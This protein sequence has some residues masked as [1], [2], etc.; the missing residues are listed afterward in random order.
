MVEGFDGCYLELPHIIHVASST[1]LL[2]PDQQLLPL[3]D[4][5][6]GITKRKRGRPSNVFSAP[7]EPRENRVS[8]RKRVVSPNLAAAEVP[9]LED[10]GDLPGDSFS[11]KRKR[12]RP[13]NASIAAQTRNEAEE[14]M[15]SRATWTER[16]NYGEKR[17]YTSASQE[18]EHEAR[19]SREKR[20]IDYA[21]KPKHTSGN[22]QQDIGEEPDAGA[23]QKKKN[24]VDK[25]RPAPVEEEVPPTSSHGLEDGPRSSREK[26]RVDYAE[27]R[28]YSSGNQENRAEEPDAGGPVQRKNRA[29]KVRSAPVEQE[30]QPTVSHAAVKKSRAGRPSKTSQAEP[31]E[32]E[33][34]QPEPRSKR[35][36]R[37][38]T[39]RLQESA[40]SREEPLLPSKKRG[41][42]SL[43]EAQIATSPL[44]TQV[45]KRGR[46]SNTNADEEEQEQEQEQPERDL[47]KRR[48]GRPSNADISAKQIKDAAG[49]GAS[50]SKKVR[51]REEDGAVAEAAPKRK[52]QRRSSPESDVDEIQQDTEIAHQRLV[53]RVHQINRDVMDTK[54]NLLPQG[55]ITQVSTLLNEAQRPVLHRL[56]PEQTRNSAHSAI[57]TIIK[58]VER[59]LRALPFPPSNRVL[60][61]EEDFDLEKILK[62]NR[63]LETQLTVVHHSNDLLMADRRREEELLERET[64]ALKKLEATIKEENIFNKAELKK[65]DHPLLK[66]TPETEDAELGDINLASRPQVDLAD[67]SPRSFIS[68]QWLIA[69]TIMQ[70][71]EDENLEPIIQQINGHMES[72][73]GNM[74]QIRDI[75]AN[76]AETRAAVEDVL[77]KQV[78]TAAYEHVVLGPT[79]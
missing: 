12:G 2:E 68:I 41:R 65:L 4:S 36:K 69:N 51:P 46:P 53:P 38:D 71:Q 24:R 56:Q 32:P 54:W 55:V 18:V 1:E 26:K 78:D 27:K 21:E 63:D 45:G 60:H 9:V 19:S 16:V 64:T 17:K 62:H 6:S 40:A 44:N 8:K 14:P 3:M 29:E 34:E 33:D 73:Q 7:S 42:P 67:V 52:K 5:T 70:L 75:G 74:E 39:S 43:T 28:R 72:M 10:E 13:S 57:S 79:E 31:E 22:H 15:S 25:V 37:K 20:R 30:V 77:F 11:K 47:R 48:R 76:I 49:N 23:L 61:R 66:K 58:K 59:R 35:A 50:T